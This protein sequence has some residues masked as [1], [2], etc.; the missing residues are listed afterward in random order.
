V[1]VYSEDAEGP[2]F[3]L[4][5][6]KTSLALYFGIETKAMLHLLTLSSNVSVQITQM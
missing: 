3:G 5:R 2:A 6:Y 4:A 1:F